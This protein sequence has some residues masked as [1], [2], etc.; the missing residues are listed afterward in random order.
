MFNVRPLSFPFETVPAEKLTYGEYTI[1][2]HRVHVRSIVDFVSASCSTG[3]SVVWEH[4]ARG[5]GALVWE[6]REEGINGPNPAFN[7]IEKGGGG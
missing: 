7:I 5:G 2:V 4:T 6:S 3:R 1:R